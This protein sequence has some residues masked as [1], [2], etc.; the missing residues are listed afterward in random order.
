MIRRENQMWTPQE[1]AAIR[2]EIKVTLERLWRTGEVHRT[3]PVV[4][5]ERRNVIYYLRNLRIGIRNSDYHF[6]RRSFFP[7]AP[8]WRRTR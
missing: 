6:C 7:D 2:D 3:K 1:Q 4:A 8:S 5:E